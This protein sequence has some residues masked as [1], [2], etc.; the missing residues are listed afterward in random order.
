[1]KSLDIFNSKGAFSL[2]DAAVI[3]RVNRFFTE[4]SKKDEE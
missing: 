3:D 1:M 2:D 4:D